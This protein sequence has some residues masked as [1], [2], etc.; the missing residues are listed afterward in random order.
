MHFCNKGW[1][2]LV[3]VT[4]DGFPSMV[5]QRSGLISLLKQKFNQDTNKELITHCCII[6]QNTFDAKILQMKSV[7]D[8]LVNW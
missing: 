1:N 2:K 6:Y 7:M 5:D 8:I 3:G 4:I